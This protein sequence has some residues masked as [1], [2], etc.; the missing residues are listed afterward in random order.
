MVGS[1]S[2]LSVAVASTPM[3]RCEAPAA[4]S[5]INVP[6]AAPVG[7]EESSFARIDTVPVVVWA[8]VIAPPCP[9]NPSMS[10]RPA[11]S[12]SVTSCSR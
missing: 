1:E 12:T 4:P 6:S 10:E 8:A 2:E 7:A 3:R 11:L 9:S 5:A